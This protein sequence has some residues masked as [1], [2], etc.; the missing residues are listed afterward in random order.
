MLGT[1]TKETK[2]KGQ[3]KVKRQTIPR[4]QKREKV[5]PSRGRKLFHPWPL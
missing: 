5:N 1:I 3:K 4:N 2:K